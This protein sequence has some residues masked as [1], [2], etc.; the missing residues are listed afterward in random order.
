[1]RAHESNINHNPDDPSKIHWGKFTLLGKMITMLQGLQDKIRTSGA[2]NFPERPFIRQ[3]VEYEVMDTEVRL[4]LHFQ[5]LE[6]ITLTDY[7][8]ARISPA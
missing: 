3:Q 4:M 5:L 7:T 6:L 8:I 1:M 2:H